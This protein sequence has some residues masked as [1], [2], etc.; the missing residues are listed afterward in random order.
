[1]KPGIYDNIDHTEYH[2]MNRISNS[3]LD[4]LAIYPALAKLEVP[5]TPIFAFGRAFHVRLLEPNLFD[6]SV[7]VLPEINKRTKAGREEYA[8]FMA[9]YKDYAVITK[10][11]L[12]LIKGMED[13]VRKHPLASRLVD[14]GLSEQTVLWTDK[15]TGIECKSRPDKIPKFDG[16]VI[17]LKKT[18]DASP[19]GFKRAMVS[20]RY[21]QQAGMYL[22]GIAQ[23]TN[24]EQVPDCFAFVAVEDKKPYR[25]EVY[26]LNEDY[27]NWGLNEYKR[28]LLLEKEC[29]DNNLWPHYQNA[30]AVEIEKPS[31]LQTYD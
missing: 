30:G 29:R 11:E 25:T 3:Y 23:A 21:P 12:E 1:M 22:D 5:D 26:T 7:K 10:E 16:V 15:E 24:G 17:D 31:Y 14:N 8:E 27:M 28:L 2:S 13:G 6:L 18:R 19:V 9:T 20:F 4:R